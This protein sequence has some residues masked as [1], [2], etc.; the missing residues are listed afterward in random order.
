MHDKLNTTR[1]FGEI[2]AGKAGLGWDT[3]APSPNWKA[4]TFMLREPSVIKHPTIREVYHYM[5]SVEWSARWVSASLPVE[6]GQTS[7]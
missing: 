2:V 7:Q 5:E 4:R 3:I 6:A 1:C